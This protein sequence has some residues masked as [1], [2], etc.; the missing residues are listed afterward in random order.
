MITGGRC[1]SLLSVP[2]RSSDRSVTVYKCVYKSV[3]D[4]VF[5]SQLEHV[6]VA[7]VP[8]AVYPCDPETPPCSRSPVP[9][10]RDGG[11]VSSSYTCLIHRINTFHVLLE[12]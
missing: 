4:G 1:R 11:R 12:W 7:D 10:A 9:A 5:F 2:I 3:I 8:E 6:C